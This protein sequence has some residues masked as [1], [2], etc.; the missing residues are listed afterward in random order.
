MR[1]L[2]IAVRLLRRN[3]VETILVVLGISAG[4]AVFV[5]IGSLVV[6][7]QARLIETTLGS[8]PHLIVSSKEPGSFVCLDKKLQNTLKK[9]DNIKRVLPERDISAV[10]TR[11]SL[12]N[13][14]Y[15]RCGDPQTLDEIFKISPKIKKGLYILGDNKIVIG[16][17]FA[18]KYGL[19]P[20]RNIFLSV[21]EKPVMRLTISGIVDFG[22]KQ[23]NETMAFSDDRFGQSAL[24]LDSDQYSVVVIQLNNVFE[25]TANAAAIAKADKRIKVADWQIEQKDLQLGLRAQAGVALIIQIFVLI[26]VALWISSS[27]SIS[28]IQ[29]TRQTDTIREL[30][31]H[32]LSAGLVFL[33]QGVILGL[34]GATGGLLLGI[35]LI[36]LFQIASAGWP[37]FF[38]IYPQMSFFVFSY[39]TGFIAAVV[40]TYLPSLAMSRTRRQPGLTQEILQKR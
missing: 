12:T 36:A 14:L 6:G 16:T 21:P 39:A 1:S 30:E 5:F 29:K 8:S 26:A 27:L 34:T 9:V 18:E 23:L 10:I 40:A 35:V 24:S 2:Q 20:G 31:L 37:V 33:W 17:A 28:A 7:L 13:P 15:I 19:N 22:S 25:S 38:P 11:G 3:P 32:D 4:V